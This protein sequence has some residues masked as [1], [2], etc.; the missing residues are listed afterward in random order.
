VQDV[1]FLIPPERWPELDAI[2]KLKV[3]DCDRCGGEGKNSGT[4]LACI[5][6]G[7]TGKQIIAGGVG[8]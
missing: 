4:S 1:R 6:C 2:Y 5:Q 8:Q 7:G 3:H